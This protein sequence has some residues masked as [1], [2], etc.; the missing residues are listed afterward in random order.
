MLCFA[1]RHS[2]RIVCSSLTQIRMLS[3]QAGTGSGSSEAAS[4]QIE[5][6]LSSM[7]LPNEKKLLDTSEPYKKP[8]FTKEEMCK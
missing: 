5:S 1:F 8:L 3:N 6:F 2:R 4:T 7:N